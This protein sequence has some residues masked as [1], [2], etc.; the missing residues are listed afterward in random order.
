MIRTLSRDGTYVI[1]ELEPG[2]MTHVGRD[3]FVTGA[4]GEPIRLRVAE[5]QPPYFIAD[6]RSGQ[7]GVGDLV[8][9]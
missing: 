1:V 8:Q 5:I 6:I 3:L 4:G 2:A 9:E 7:P